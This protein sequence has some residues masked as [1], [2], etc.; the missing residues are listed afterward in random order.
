MIIPIL[1]LK[2]QPVLNHQE[3]YDL[4]SAYLLESEAAC[5]I[6]NVVHFTLQNSSSTFQLGLQLLV[7]FSICPLPAGRGLIKLGFHSV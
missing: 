2:P 3:S 5:Y 1:S 4:L 7:L 6:A